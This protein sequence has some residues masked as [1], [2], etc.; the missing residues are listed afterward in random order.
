MGGYQNNSW[1][2]KKDNIG[3]HKKVSVM[4]ND[5]TTILNLNQEEIDKPRFGYG[6]ENGIWKEKNEHFSDKLLSKLK[7]N[8][9]S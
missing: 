6:I 3:E 8:F 9:E 2:Y 4:S 5:D 7:K 1:S